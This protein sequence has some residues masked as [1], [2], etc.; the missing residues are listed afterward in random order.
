MKP[1]KVKASITGGRRRWRRRVS[2]PVARKDWRALLNLPKG[3]VPE[4]W[5]VRAD[6]GLSAIYTPTP[7]P[8]NVVFESERH[9]E[10]P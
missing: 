8:T 5:L 9:K 1:N 7:T 3:A 6:L 2:F 4:D 10:V